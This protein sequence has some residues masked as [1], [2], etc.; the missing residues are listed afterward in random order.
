MNT[1]IAN[2]KILYNENNI[3]NQESIFYEL[4]KDFLTIKSMEDQFLVA[5]NI[6]L[7]NHKEFMKK[8]LETGTKL[9]ERSHYLRIMFTKR[10]DKI[11][12]IC[13]CRSIDNFTDKT[14]KGRVKRGRDKYLCIEVC[15]SNAYFLWLNEKF[16][17]YYI[18]KGEIQNHNVFELDH[19]DF[20]KQ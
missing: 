4:D 18:E 19:E 16:L 8:F 13:I 20:G 17:T 10:D 12:L 6:L 2:S 7:R 3:E 5:I 11:I 1:I 15:W 14:L 9:Y